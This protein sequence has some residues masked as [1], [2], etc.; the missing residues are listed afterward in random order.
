[1]LLLL[2]GLLNLSYAIENMVYYVTEQM[3]YSALKWHDKRSDRTAEEHD[4]RI[5]SLFATDNAYVCNIV[6]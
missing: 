1:M 2:F 5:V 3:M 4:K 6:T